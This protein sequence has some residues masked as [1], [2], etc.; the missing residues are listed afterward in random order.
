MI[1]KL[2]KAH[3]RLKV[4]HHNLIFFSF[5]GFFLATILAVFGTRV[6][7]I[8]LIE[9]AFMPILQRQFQRA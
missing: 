5:V 3:K 9:E 6:A 7:A 2:H 8:E 1:K 4:V